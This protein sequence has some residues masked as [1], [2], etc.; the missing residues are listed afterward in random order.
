MHLYVHKITLD[1]IHGGLDVQVLERYTKY[2]KARNEGSHSIH[3][4]IE[5]N[6]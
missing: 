1:P 4:V 3:L 6:V 2:R 5:L